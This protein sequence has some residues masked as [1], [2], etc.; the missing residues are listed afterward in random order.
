MV[1][2][3]KWLSQITMFTKQDCHVTW[4]PV[5]DWFVQNYGHRTGWF[6]TWYEISIKYYVIVINIFLQNACSFSVFVDIG[7][8]RTRYTWIPITHFFQ[9]VEIELVDS[10][11]SICCIYIIIWFRLS[12]CMYVCLY[13]CMSVLAVTRS[14]L[15]GN[16]FKNGVFAPIF[17]FSVYTGSRFSKPKVVCRLN[18][19]NPSSSF[20]VMRVQ[21]TDIQT[22]IHTDIH[23]YRQTDGTKIW[24]RRQNF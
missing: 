7:L 11:P 12:V 22:Y 17:N 18:F 1:L 20:W 3:L 13:V 10:Q 24:Y 23:T 2:L 4:I 5:A 16:V 19:E 15:N 9:K 8:S 14:I 6:E 21:H